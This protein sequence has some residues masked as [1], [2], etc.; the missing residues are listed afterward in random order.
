VHVYRE[1]ATIALATKLPR[2]LKAFNLKRA[3]IA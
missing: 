3:L 1:S 2:I